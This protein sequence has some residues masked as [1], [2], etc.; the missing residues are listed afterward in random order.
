MYPNLFYA[1]RDI[2]GIET[3][4][5]A[6]FINSFGFF[7]A[8]AFIVAAYILTREFKR[9]EKQGLIGYKEEKVIAGKPASV[10]ELIVNFVLGFILGYK[11][12]GAFISGSAAASNP[13][14]FILSAQGNLSAGLILGFFFAGLKWYEKHKQRL[15]KP[16]ERMIRIWAHDRVGDIVILGVIFGFL[17]SKIFHNFENWNEFTKDPIGAL[18]SFSGLT[19]YGGLICAAL[20]IMWYAKRKGIHLRHLI[21][22]AAP[23]LMIAYAIGRIG[24]QVSGDG[25]WGIYNSAYTVNPEGEI[26]LATSPNQF[27]QSLEGSKAYFA[28][29]FGSLEAVPHRSVPKPSALSFL[30]DW[31]FAYNYPHNVNSVGIRMKGCDE[32]QHCSQ[33]PVPVFPTPFY[34]TI[35]CTLLFLLLWNI[36]K[37]IKT[38][39]SLFAIYLMVNGLERFFIEKIRVNTHYNILGF[40]PTQAEIISTSLIIIGIVLFFLFRRKKVAE[41]LKS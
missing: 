15:D 36:R 39:G 13:Q 23:A 22:A 7:V 16:E 18:L 11:I 34:E 41:P 2:F 6:K 40:R 10:A 30:P 31:F 29:E 26:S 9:K 35:T 37:K 32:E 4:G 24:C 27:K 17:G 12:I 33:L 3:G 25:D 14:D 1:L 38:P 21:D 8:L 20:A 28:H 5:W 19:F